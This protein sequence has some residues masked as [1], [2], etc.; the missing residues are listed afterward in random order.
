MQTETE[1]VTVYLGERDRSFNVTITATYCPGDYYTPSDIEYEISEI[2][3]NDN[4]CDGIDLIQRWENLYKE[5]FN[6][7]A[8]EEFRNQ[9]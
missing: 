9:Y 3:D 5:D 1:T 6:S 7:L 4:C 2:W 8:I